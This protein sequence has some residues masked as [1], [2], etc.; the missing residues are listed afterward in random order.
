MYKINIVG[1]IGIGR[2]GAPMVQTV[3]ESVYKVAIWN[4][5]RSKADALTPY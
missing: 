4:R 3:L 1:W 5:T 2:M